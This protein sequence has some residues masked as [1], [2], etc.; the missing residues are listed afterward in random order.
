MSLARTIKNGLKK[1]LFYSLILKSL[2]FG[3]D[4]IKSVTINGPEPVQTNLALMIY[5]NIDLYQVF[6][7]K[8][9]SDNNIQISII[10]E[11]LTSFP[12][13]DRTPFWT[14]DDI[15]A[16]RDLFQYPYVST[17]DRVN[18]QVTVKN[19][20]DD[21]INSGTTNNDLLFIYLTGHGSLNTQP[22]DTYV[23]IA[24]S[25]GATTWQ[26]L[27]LDSGKVFHYHI[28]KALSMIN[29]KRCV[30]LTDACN[31]YSLAQYINKDQSLNNTNLQNVI[32]ISAS[33]GDLAGLS[34]GHY[35]THLSR[36]GETIKRSV[37]ITDSLKNIEGAPI[38]SDILYFGNQTDL[39]N[40]VANYNLFQDSPPG[41]IRLATTNQTNLQM[42]ARNGS[43]QFY[44]PKQQNVNLSMYN[45]PG[46]LLE[47]IINQNLQKGNYQAKTKQ[48]PAGIYIYK[49][50]T[51]EQEIAK[52]SINLK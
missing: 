31:S 3:Y 16:G 4:N 21:I 14:L 11:A 34:F 15:W 27:P 28:N 42:Q 35:F 40:F 5:P 47:T 10:K 17:F 1:G 8:G 24:G 45:A 13:T 38:Q 7:E 25:A 18:N 51:Q 19:F 30:I 50:K 33:R 44:I 49:L 2:A 39:S 6:R 52:K 12:M 29:F 9:I 41:I 36:T 37:E 22:K 48:M 46:Q 23:R 20:L 26:G 32:V 43:I